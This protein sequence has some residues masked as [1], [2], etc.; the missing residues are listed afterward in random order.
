MNA[1][2]CQFPHGNHIASTKSAQKS[3]DDHGKRQRRRALSSS[4]V[5]DE[6]RLQ[7]FNDRM[8]VTLDLKLKSFKGNTRGP[9]IQESFVTLED[10]LLKLPERIPLNMEISKNSPDR[11]HTDL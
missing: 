5:N 8:R 4:S 11:C 6:L 9:F 7:D 1:S 2:Q 10:L 3:G